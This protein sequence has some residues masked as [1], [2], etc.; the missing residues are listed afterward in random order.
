M[1]NFAAIEKVLLD[2][3][4]MLYFCDV[5]ILDRVFHPQAL[6][7]TAD[8]KPALFRSKDEYRSV[9]ATRQSPASRHEIRKDKIEKIELAGENTAFVRARCSIGQR[10]FIDFLTFIYTDGEWQI[11]SKVFHFTDRKAI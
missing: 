6:Y 9:I 10:D 5:E 4:D 7:A 8:E 1:S 11:I 3:F 2:Y